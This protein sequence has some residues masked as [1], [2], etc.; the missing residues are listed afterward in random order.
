MSARSVGEP[1]VRADGRAKVT[2]QARYSA[3]VQVSGI[4]YAV[5]VTSGV[6]KGRVAEI[7][8][9]AAEKEPGVIAVLTH[10][11]ALRLPGDP[12]PAD[13]G[14]RVVQVLQDDRILYSNQ[15][16]A[17]AVA[18]TFERAVHAALLVRVREQGE[19][20]LPLGDGTDHAQLPRFCDPGPQTG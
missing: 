4:A 14:D 1:L 11:N 8:A 3:E 12:K 2:G 9:S 16:I 19:P 7:D 13:R 5:M 15:P 10:Q 18:D 17:L 6:A 20:F